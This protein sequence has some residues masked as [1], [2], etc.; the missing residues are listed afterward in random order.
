MDR[1]EHPRY[2]VCLEI[3]IREATSCFSSRGTTTDASLGGCYIA[4]IFP[5]SVGS[6]V[7]YRLWVGDQPIQGC[8]RVQT[9]HPGVGMG[10]QFIDMSDEASSILDLH[11]RT[12]SSLPMHVAFSHLRTF[13]SG[14]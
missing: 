1:R 13:Q 6:L 8:A 10:I 12:S 4:T 14:K 2:M 11:L 7:N 3:E 9:C 5:M